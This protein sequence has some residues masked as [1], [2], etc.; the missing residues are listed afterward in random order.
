M[1][2]IRLMGC[3]SVVKH[4][5]LRWLLLSALLGLIVPITLL[6]I[7][8]PARGTSF[9]YPLHRLMI[10]LWPSSFW[11][12]ATEGIEGTPRAY[13]FT[14]MSIVANMVVYGAMGCLLWGVKLIITTS[15]R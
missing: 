2:A 15:R 8:M 6:L 13:L 1:I 3:T 14:S 12:L 10:L 7:Q 5:F 11:L 4:P 9:S